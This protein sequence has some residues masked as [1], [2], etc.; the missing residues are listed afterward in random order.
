MGELGEQLGELEAFVEEEASAGAD[1]RE[2]FAQC[3]LQVGVSCVL[4]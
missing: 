4:A 1:D 2:Y 3:R